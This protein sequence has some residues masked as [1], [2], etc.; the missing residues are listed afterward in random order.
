[1]CNPGALQLSLRLQQVPLL[2]VWQLLVLSEGTMARNHRF[3]WSVISSYEHIIFLWRFCYHHVSRKLNC[4]QFC[5]TIA[6]LN[7]ATSMHKESHQI[8]E[9]L[10]FRVLIDEHSPRIPWSSCM[11]PHPISRVQLAYDVK[12]FSVRKG[13]Q[14]VNFISYYLHSAGPKWH[15]RK[16][17]SSA[18]RC[19]LPVSPQR[20][21]WPAQA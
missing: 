20:I 5:S 16:W 4:Q 21:H 6:W 9:D 7:F 12:T 19:R 1:M 17:A 11:L 3:C 13:I 15:T 14:L 10:V 8:R 18:L 2:V